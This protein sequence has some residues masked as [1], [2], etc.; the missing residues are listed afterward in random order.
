MTLQRTLTAFF[1]F[2]IS[3]AAF[4]AQATNL[5]TNG[6]FTN[7]T[8]P[9][10][11]S[12]A[13]YST[14]NNSD[15]SG[16]QTTSGYSFVVTAAQATGGF[17]GPSGGVS[18]YGPITASPDGGYFLAAD[19]GYQTGYTYTSVS[20]LTAGNQYSVSFYQAAAQQT[21]YSGATTDYWQVG[22]G[23]TYGSSTFINATLMSDA[24]Q[25]SV[26]WQ[27]QTLTF[28]AVAS[29]EILSFMAV[30]TPTGQPPFALL[31]GVTITQ[32]V[33]EP[34]SLTLMAAGLL[35]LAGARAWYNRRVRLPADAV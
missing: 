26:G 23:T 8:P 6:S 27:L 29:T 7:F 4:P 30:G 34:A 5:V 18:F 9:P 16:W 11:G 19:G 21:G 20:G 12:N 17:N 1:L 22:L 25:S 13:F 2:L 32:A 24:S 15:L 31:D 28:T 10:D 33:P 3:A 35:V 14:L